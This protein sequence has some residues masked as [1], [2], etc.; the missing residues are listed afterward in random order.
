MRIALC[1]SGLAGGDK[2]KSGEGSS[3]DVLN[4]SFEHFKKHIL[5]INNVDIFIHSWSLESSDQIKKLYNP[6]KEIFEEQIWW[7]RD[8]TR[9]FR[10]NNHFSK[11]YSMK[12]SIE[13]KSDYEKENG[14]KYDF[15]MNS[16]FDIAWQTDVNFSNFEQNSFYAG[17]WNRRYF[18]NEKEIK[19]RLYYNYDITPEQYT[20]KLVGYPHNEEGL[21]D[22][23]FFANSDNMNKFSTLFDN[24]VEYDKLGNET[25]DHEGAISNH[26]MA[27]HHLK[28]IELIEHLKFSFFLHDDFPLT[29]RIHFKCGR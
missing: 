9:N 14:F 25:H 22:Q 15:V 5:D 17:N 24:I 28:E 29:R 1:F 26:R 11:W 8:P 10:R 7:D 20:E 6:K 23:W 16:R 12:K 21:I 13:L 27:I 3:V 2:G 4:I 18:L 19:N